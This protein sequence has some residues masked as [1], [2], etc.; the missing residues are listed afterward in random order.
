V[1]L[2]RKMQR[3]KK[4]HASI[5]ED[6]D[7]TLRP[8]NKEKPMQAGEC[9][10]CKDIVCPLTQCQYCKTLLC[11][12]RCSDGGKV[13]G[14]INLAC[15]LLRCHKCEAQQGCSFCDEK[16]K[17]KKH[18]CESTPFAPSTTLCEG[19]GGGTGNHGINCPMCKKLLCQG[20]GN[21]GQFRVPQFP[22]APLA[23]C[24]V[25]VCVVCMKAIACT[26]CKPCCPQCGPALRSHC[27]E[28]SCIQEQCAGAQTAVY[29]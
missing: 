5:E 13:P 9:K 20:L 1:L 10:S 27:S 17:P 19:C 23:Q 6:E 4:Q 14:P 24:F 12:N 7:I 21:H 2:L 28:P 25:R 11:D 18:Q 3:L 8:R 15:A 29:Q 22:V 26:Q 16:Q